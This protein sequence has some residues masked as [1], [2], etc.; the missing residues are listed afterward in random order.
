[1]QTSGPVTLSL[2]YLR[3]QFRYRQEDL[4]YRLGVTRLTI[5]RWESGQ[6]KPRSEHIT[7][8]AR[9]FDVPEWLIRDSLKMDLEGV[10]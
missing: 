6:T 1:M 2:R 3:S 9:I 10:A 7:E 4:A 8:L 5:L